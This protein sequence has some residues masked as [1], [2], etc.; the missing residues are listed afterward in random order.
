MARQLI[1]ALRLS[2]HDVQVASRLRVFL[3]DPN[4]ASF[5]TTNVRAEAEVERLQSEWRLSGAPQLWF[6]YHPYY[7]APDLLGPALCRTARIPYVT[8]EASWSERRGGGAW[9]VTQELVADAV[10]LA[11]VNICFTAR[12]RIGLLQALPSARVGMLPPFID[13]SHYEALVPIDNSMRLV[14]VAM[15]R[16]GDKFDSY[17]ML[18]AALAL[19][20]DLPWTLTVLGGGKQQPD[21]EALFAEFPPQRIDWLGE[22]DPERV[23]EILCRGGIFVW[24]GCGEAYGLS[25]LEAQAAGLPVVAQNTAG[26]PEVVRHGMTGLLT[27][28]SD[29]HSFA[30]AVRRLLIAKGE[31]AAMAAAA[32][33]F[34]LEDRS[35]G[36]A[37]RHLDKLLPEAMGAV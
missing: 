20:L 36:G 4:P 31:R 19:I 17:R 5:A 35:L 28:A 3:P 23:A 13:T 21:V 6:C 25:Y 8:A 29:V 34:V 7:K 14:T 32:R 18:S 2:G 1:E 15:M 22:V 33:R 16:S 37:A 11:H 12:D 24:P 30:K 10:G 26:V 9:S 27:P